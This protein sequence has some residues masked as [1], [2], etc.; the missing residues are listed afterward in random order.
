MEGGV[1]GKQKVDLGLVEVGFG[2]VRGSL[3]LL[4]ARSLEIL[5]FG[6]LQKK[7]QD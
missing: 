5:V 2:L 4:G 6:Y 3:A 1:K 7:L